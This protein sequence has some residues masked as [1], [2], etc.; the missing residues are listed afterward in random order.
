MGQD[1]SNDEL[2]EQGGIEG[3]DPYDKM[4]VEEPERD[5]DISLPK[6]LAGG[7]GPMSL[8]DAEMAPNMS[9]L[10]ST[11]MHL[12]PQ[13]RDTILAK[14]AQSV[15]AVMVSRISPDR[16]LE[17][18]SLTV[19]SILEEM[20]ADEETSID[21]QAVIN[22]VDTAFSI[23]LEGK[24]RIEVIQCAGAARESAELDQ[25]AKGLGIG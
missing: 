12:F 18:S 17:L 4:S 3:G 6:S 5:I 9:D 14:V 16:F 1:K 2:D 10:Q 22:M 7:S 11:L 21:V 20:D 24:G 13:F 8:S 19:D 23:G 15:Q 25:V